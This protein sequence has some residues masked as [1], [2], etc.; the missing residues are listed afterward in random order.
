MFYGLGEIKYVW[1][2][3]FTLVLNDCFVRVMTSAKE[4]VKNAIVLFLLV[5]DF[6]IL[7]GFKYLSDGIPLGISFYT[8]QLAAYVL[9]VYWG[10]CK[11]SRNLVETGTYLCMYPQLI[12]GPIL[13]Y[14]DVISQIRYRTY[15]LE[16]IEDGMKLFVLGLAYKLL[17]AD[18]LGMLWHQVLVVGFESISTPMAWLGAAAFSMEIYFDF[19]GYSLMAVGLGKM[20]GFKF[21]DNF[22]VPYMSRSVSEFFRR[23]HISLGQWFREYVY[24]PLGGNRKGRILTIRNLFIV[25]V[26]TG[27]W[28]GRTINFLVWAMGI[29]LLIV[30]ERMGFKAVLQKHSVVSR[31]YMILFIPVSWMIFAISDIGELLVYF[32]K[33]FPIGQNFEFIA[34]NGRDTIMALQQYGIILF[35]AIFLSTGILRNLYQENKRKWWMLLILIVLFWLSVIHMIKNVE[36]PFLY[37]RF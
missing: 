6:G 5:Y 33:M 8:F 18:M 29:F 12:A 21:M 7:I 31:I 16:K 4:L 3:L 17:I 32:K 19:N 34:G 24:I 11:P 23:W 10:K 28:H 36:N 2:L 9:D 27:M 25:W 26:L 1:L 20:L 35:A 13:L 30:I 15:K 14:K 37:F 22:N